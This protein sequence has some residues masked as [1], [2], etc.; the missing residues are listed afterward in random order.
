[1]NPTIIDF[2]EYAR[3]VCRGS[4]EK[5]VRDLTAGLVQLVLAAESS[6]LRRSMAAEKAFKRAEGILERV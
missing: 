6:Y 3:H 4:S 5:R 2:I 1:M